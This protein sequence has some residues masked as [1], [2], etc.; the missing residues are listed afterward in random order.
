MSY[1]ASIECDDDDVLAEARAQKLASRHYCGVH[2]DDGHLYCD[3]DSGEY[4]AYCECGAHDPSDP[5]DRDERRTFI[6]ADDDCP[7]F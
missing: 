1:W 4:C 2:G 7:P 6:L 3:E 5:A